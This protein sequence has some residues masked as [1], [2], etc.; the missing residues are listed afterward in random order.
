M[1]W[2]ETA[3]IVAGWRWSETM[4]NQL[5]PNPYAPTR[6]VGEPL[7]RRESDASPQP[8]VGVMAATFG[9]IV[10]SGAGFGMILGG[11]IAISEPSNITE[12]VML[13]PLGMVV[14]AVIAGLSGT[15]TVIVLVCLSAP[16]VPL[17][18]G[19]RLRQIRYFAGICGFLSGNLPVVLLDVRD[20]YSWLASLLPGVF[21]AAGTTLFVRW[22]FGAGQREI[23]NHGGR[24]LEQQSRN[25]VS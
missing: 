18:V 16:L 6:L 12:L 20:P 9:G 4:T 1:K 7:P 15:A 24:T 23:P 22:I 17:A 25:N 14:G 11:I 8:T 13:L 2:Q 3:R 21:G 5:D 19:W 10:L